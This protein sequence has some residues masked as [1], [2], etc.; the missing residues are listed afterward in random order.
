MPISGD[1]AALSRREE[2]RQ[3]DT[4][5]LTLG[6]RPWLEE[7]MLVSRAQSAFDAEG[8][9]TDKATRQRLAQLI[10][11]FAALAAER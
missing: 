3:P 8:N 2:S 11:G 6:T 4:R 9:L 10:A 7:R 5:I 1:A